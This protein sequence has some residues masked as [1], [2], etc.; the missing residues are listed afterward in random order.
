ML[1]YIIITITITIIKISNSNNNSNSN[2]DNDNDN[3]N[4]NG[5]S[6]IN[7]PK[8]VPPNMVYKGMFDLKGF[9]FQPFWS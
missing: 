9:F 1:D 4:N 8:G 7:T 2:N 6:A 3:D 5:R